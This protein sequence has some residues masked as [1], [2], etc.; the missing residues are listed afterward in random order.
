MGLPDPSGSMCEITVPNPLGEA[1]IANIN[2]NSG[3]NGVRILVLVS[4]CFNFGNTVSHSFDHLQ[5]VL[6]LSI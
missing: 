4:S 5:C 2:S 6:F 3:E 1:S